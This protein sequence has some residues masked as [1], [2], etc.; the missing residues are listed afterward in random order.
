MTSD[1][2]KE[3]K[4]TDEYGRILSKEQSPEDENRTMIKALNTVK[5][6][7]HDV[8]TAIPLSF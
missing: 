7:D 2:D 5:Q 6:R 1:E 3:R 8:G 4:S